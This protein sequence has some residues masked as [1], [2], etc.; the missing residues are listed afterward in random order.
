MDSSVSSY[1]EVAQVT[2]FVAAARKAT[3][4]FLFAGLGVV[5]GGP[6]FDIDAPAWKLAASVG[7]GAVI[8]LVYRWAEH[9]KDAD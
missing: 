2:K 7:L 8:N 4:T 1:W 6:A 9:A 5:V 3:A